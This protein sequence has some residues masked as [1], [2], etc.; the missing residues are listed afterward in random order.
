MGLRHRKGK[1]CQNQWRLVVRAHRVSLQSY[2]L[3]NL[4][5]YEINLFVNEIKTNTGTH[6]AQLLDAKACGVYV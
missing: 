4:L 5:K 6:N 2:V 3:L 1:T